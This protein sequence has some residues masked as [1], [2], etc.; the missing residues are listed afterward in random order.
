MIIGAPK[1]LA[2]YAPLTVGE[3]EHLV[4]MLE[5]AIASGAP[6]EMQ[7]AVDFGVLCRLVSTCRVLH[8]K[9]ATLEAPLP[10]LPKFQPSTEQVV[11][12]SKEE[13]ANGE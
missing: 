6:P 7:A 4:P 11:E 3:V 12:Q 10:E 2:A 8:A 5:Q 1:N 13:I 9:V